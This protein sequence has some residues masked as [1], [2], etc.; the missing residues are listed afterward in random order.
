[1]AAALPSAAFAAT[2]TVT[3]EPAPYGLDFVGP[4]QE[5]AIDY[6]AT[7]GSL[8][9]NTYG[10]GG[11]DLEGEMFQGGGS[12]GFASAT[13]GGLFTFLGLDYATYQAMSLGSQSLT[14]RG[15][16]NGLTI[17][18]DIFTLANAKL[19][20]GDQA[21]ANWTSFTATNL[22][23]R[24]LTALQIDLVG[25]GTGAGQQFTQAIDNVR[26]GNMVEID[27]PSSPAPEPATW[28]TMV[29]G[30]GVAGAAL[31]RRRTG[32]LVTA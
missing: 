23:G 11:Y 4:V 6:Q 28:G 26:F 18:T 29:A 12:V 2:T 8:V 20:D 16:L 24:A 14:V 15:Y 3:F 22:A 31:R 1:M 13:P 32:A 5:G 7:S 25:G 30:F 17:A 19:G 9:V 21:F 10:N 27:V